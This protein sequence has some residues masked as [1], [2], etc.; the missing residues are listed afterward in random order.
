MAGMW[1]LLRNPGNR[2]VLSTAFEKPS[3]EIAGGTKK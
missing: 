1:I 2:T 3:G